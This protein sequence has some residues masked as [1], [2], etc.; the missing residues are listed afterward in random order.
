MSYIVIW[1]C[2]LSTNT[3]EEAAIEALNR[4]KKFDAI[5]SIINTKNG[6]KWLVDLREESLEK[7]DMKNV[8]RRVP[9]G[10]DTR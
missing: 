10:T 7:S 8:I 6:E 1:E 9:H 3:P 2:V 5:F 4:I